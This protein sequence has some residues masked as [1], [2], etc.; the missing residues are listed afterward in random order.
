MTWPSVS[1]KIELV[2]EQKP[3]AAGGFREVYKAK[4]PTKG[5]SGRSWVLKKYLPKT[6]EFIEELKQTVED[7]PKKKLSKCSRLPEILRRLFMQE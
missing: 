2:V 7:H 5:Y 6:L 1:E 4:S 3:F